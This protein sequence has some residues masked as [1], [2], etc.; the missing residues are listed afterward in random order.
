MLKYAECLILKKQNFY[1]VPPFWATLYSYR[2]FCYADFSKPYNF[3]TV[4]FLIMCAIFEIITR[5]GNFYTQCI[6][7]AFNNCNVRFI[8]TP[9][10][11]TLWLWCCMYPWHKYYY[12]FFYQHKTTVHPTYFKIISKNNSTTF[13]FTRKISQEM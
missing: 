13:I 10:K 6:Y 12:L 1:L 4:S 2:Y 7:W 3:P 8:W 5:S 9:F 11:D